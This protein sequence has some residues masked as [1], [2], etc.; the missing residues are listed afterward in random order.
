MLIITRGTQGKKIL[1]VC[2]ILIDDTTD[3]AFC[4]QIRFPK[5][6][7]DMCYIK[8]AII[9]AD[10]LSHI[11]CFRSRCG[12]YLMLLCRAGNNCFLQWGDI[13]NYYIQHKQGSNFHKRVRFRP[14]IMH[15][16]KFRLKFNLFKP[17]A[18]IEQ[19]IV[20][21]QQQL[22]QLVQHFALLYNGCFT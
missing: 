19:K 6:N 21:F 22:I 10:S 5:C 17:I 12:N 16:T 15:G 9:K 18:N 20:I 8:D 14:A 11:F 1:L 4:Y 2:L 3:S 7:I 13:Q